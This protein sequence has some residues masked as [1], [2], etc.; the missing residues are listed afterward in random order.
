MAAESELSVLSRQ[1]INRRV[2]SG[3]VLER[4]VCRWEEDRNDQEVCVDW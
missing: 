1:C 4:E 2:D 3:L